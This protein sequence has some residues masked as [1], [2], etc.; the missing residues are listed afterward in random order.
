M[1][2]F[3]AAFGPYAVAEVIHPKPGRNF[4]GFGSDGSEATGDVLYIGS[5]NY[6]RMIA[7]KAF[8]E[9]IT[10]NCDKD[11]TFTESTDQNYKVYKEYNGKFSYNVTLNLPAHSANESRNNL[12]KIAEL[13]RLIMPIESI[14]ETSKTYNT[15]EIQRISV[16]YKNLINSG[17]HYE[18]LPNIQSYQDLYKYGFSCYIEEVKYEPDLDVG[19]FTYDNFLYPKVI[20]LNLTLNYETQYL[21]AINNNQT[22]F[23]PLESFVTD[24]RYG[25]FDSGCFPFL[26]RVHN[27]LPQTDFLEKKHV[28]DQGPRD[29]SVE[30]M[31]DLRYQSTKEESYI[32]ISLMNYEIATV[33]FRPV[34]DL[35][36]EQTND[37]FSQITPELRKLIPIK[38]K[39][40]STAFDR[41]VLFKPF[42]EVFDRNV[43]TEFA[44]IQSQDASLSNTVGLQ[45]F[46]GIEYN[47]TFN[48]PAQSLL[49]AKK[50]CAKIQYLMRMFYKK[51]K[52]SDEDQVADANHLFVYIPYKI[53]KAGASTKPNN[54]QFQAMKDNAVALIPESLTI[55]I[56]E[57][58]GFF[59]QKGKVYPKNFKITMKFELPE[60]N[61][62]SNFSKKGPFF[63]E[64]LEGPSGQEKGAIRGGKPELFP[65]NRSYST[66]I[67]QKK[68]TKVT[69]EGE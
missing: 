68:T 43:K 21:K 19:F 48:V 22:L 50:N 30:G 37:P 32:F 46:K 14:A 27:G 24:G 8:I 15:G 56:D 41:F 23:K 52:Q 26:L 17:I 42:I 69:K 28:R 31:N 59:N 29:F 9:N 39:V 55:E 1:A 60:Q 57:D 66:I 58:V 6:E 10:I 65:F 11:G 33:N 5:D 12:A 36:R 35:V 54:N 38:D 63:Y 3:P 25:D 49:E 67:G 51:T 47:L 64:V 44:K 2:R 53:E 13:Q 16:F 4:R 7:F 20:K 61:N 45:S 34:N 62:L 40:F 18:Q